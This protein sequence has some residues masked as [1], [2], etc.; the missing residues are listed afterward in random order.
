MAINTTAI[1]GTAPIKVLYT[2]TMWTHK[3]E[4]RATY[5][6]LVCLYKN[7]LVTFT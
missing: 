2:F 3:G 1:D 4:I 7:Q 5:F 6:K